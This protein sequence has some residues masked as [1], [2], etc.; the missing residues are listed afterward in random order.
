M[1]VKRDIELE[2]EV[3]AYHLGYLVNKIFLFQKRN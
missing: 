1:L 3:V 2:N